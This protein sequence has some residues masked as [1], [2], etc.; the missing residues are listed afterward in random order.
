MYCLRC[1]YCLKGVSVNCPECGKG[2]DVERPS[3]YRTFPRKF[4]ATWIVGALLLVSLLAFGSHA[5]YHRAVRVERLICIECLRTREARYKVYGPIWQRLDSEEC[6]NSLLDVFAGTHIPCLRHKWLVVFCCDIAL[7]TGSESVRSNNA[8]LNLLWSI[9]P[10]SS[11]L[12]NFPTASEKGW[13]RAIKDDLVLCSN[14]AASLFR[15]KLL[16]R[17]WFGEVSPEDFWREWE[18]ATKH[19]SAAQPGNV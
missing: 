10:D 8:A 3:S 2:F 11:D 4:R 1:N 13:G 5:F 18:Q 12:S 16:L 7:V 6:G 19:K 17:A 9:R 15:A 14:E